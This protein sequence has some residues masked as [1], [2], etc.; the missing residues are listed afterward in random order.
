MRL[1]RSLLLLLLLPLLAEAQA[2]ANYT[3]KH[4]LDDAS[5]YT[6]CSTRGAQG[7][8]YGGPIAGQGRLTTTGSSTT[9]EASSTAAFANMV[10][11]T[12]PVTRSAMILVSTDGGSSYTAYRVASK[13]D[14][15]TIV[16]DTAVNYASPGYVWSWYDI[17]CGTTV[18]DGWIA[19]GPGSSMTFEYNAGTGNAN[20]VWECR[21]GANGANPVQVY[22]DN[23]AAAAS[24]LYAA[25]GSDSRTIFAIGPGIPC[26]YARIGM[27][28]T[29]PVV[30]A[31]I[32]RGK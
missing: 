22:P 1:L 29:S 11:D 21:S 28:G 15:D 14:D 6:Y 32:N 10:V 13:T 26:D 17:R 19:A 5:N 20:V 12:G 18:N 9:V 3:F 30:T 24:R 2:I 25:A 16:I 8:P 27:K 23:S 4:T 7:N 31:Y